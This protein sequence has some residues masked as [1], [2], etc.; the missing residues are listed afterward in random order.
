MFHL[1]KSSNVGLLIDSA[2][3]WPTHPTLVSTEYFLTL[4]FSTAFFV[5]T[6]DSVFGIIEPFPIYRSGLECR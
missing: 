4:C 2:Y 1:I 5:R 3:G 6:Y